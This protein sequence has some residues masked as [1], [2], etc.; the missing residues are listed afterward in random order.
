MS[1]V[2]T[3]VPVT[4]HK[5]RVV[6]LDVLRGV[7]ILG[8]LIP[9]I[10]GFSSPGGMSMEAP[11]SET[12]GPD[13]WVEVLRAVFFSGKFRGML[14]ILFG[15]G[16]AMQFK[17]LSDRSGEWPD[18]YLRRT[19]L[20]LVIGLVHLL[21]VWHGD[22]L[23]VYS[24]AALL[25]IA[26]VRINDRAVLTTAVLV[27]G[28][29]IMLGVLIGAY[30][31]IDWANSSENTGLFASLSEEAELA[32]YSGG[33]IFDQLQHRF[34]SALMILSLLPIIVPHIFGGFLVGM[35]L[36][37]KGVLAAPSRHPRVRNL[38]LLVGFGVGVPMTLLPLVGFLVGTSYNFSMPLE[39][40]G[41]VVLGLGYV[42]LGAV[43]V[44]RLREGQLVKTIANVGRLALS[45]YLLQSVL[46]T[47]VFY[48]WGGGL[49][50]QFGPVD[51]L[52]F[53]LAT[54]VVV[55]AFAALWSR[56]FLFG[57]VE[58]LWRSLNYKTRLSIKSSRSSS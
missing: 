45:C 50:G 26:F 36:G 48:S 23:F 22:I 18:R 24:I 54:W 58:W 32:A 57:P 25:A 6:A 40:G 28:A 15:V 33:T 42:M 34:F 37:R 53:V 51:Q 12:F 9:N 55:L 4:T 35:L 20:L 3:G 19:V 2:A 30:S 13:A 49:Y 8:I 11:G 46:L 41:G 16:L 27:L 7:A 52:P 5:T 38:S 17:K 1:E 29:S 56:F 39:M 14:S 44:E 43:L 10:V 31:M 21:F 47:C